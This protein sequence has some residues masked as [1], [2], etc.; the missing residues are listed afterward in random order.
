[1]PSIHSNTIGIVTHYK[2]VAGWAFTFIT[3]PKGPM[4]AHPV[5]ITHGSSSIQYMMCQ[6]VL[7]VINTYGYRIDVHVSTTDPVLRKFPN[8]L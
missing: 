3:W 4:G 2:P 7:F 5:I 1:M 8:P 6:N